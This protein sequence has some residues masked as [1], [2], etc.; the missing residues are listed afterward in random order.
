MLV[1]TVIC[2]TRISYVPSVVGYLCI[3]TMCVTQCYNV[4]PP[5]FG[6]YIGLFVFSLPR[7]CVDGDILATAACCG[8]SSFRRVFV[9]WLSFQKHIPISA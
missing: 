1:R 2:D 8:C 6:L 3:Y 9:V 7:S 5:S 4:H